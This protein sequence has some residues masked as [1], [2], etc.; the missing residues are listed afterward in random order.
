MMM[1]FPLF[2][3][4]VLV[5]YGILV[6]LRTIAASRTL[7][8]NLLHTIVRCPISFFDTTPSGRIINRFSHDMGAV[9]TSLPRSIQFIIFCSTS[10]LAV[11]AAITY[12]AH[13][14]LLAVIPLGITYYLIMVILLM[15]KHIIRFKCPL[16]KTL[17]TIY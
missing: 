11:L 8:A 7:H 4:T 14:F 16:V 17:S 3:V 2:A 13:W 9:D 10:I 1:R 12:S 15:L 5:L 6:V